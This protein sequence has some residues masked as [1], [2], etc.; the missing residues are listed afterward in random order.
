MGDEV[1]MGQLAQIV[2]KVVREEL[3][4]DNKRLMRELVEIIADGGKVKKGGNRSER[5]VLV[6]S[7]K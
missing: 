7:P 1:S 6:V 4:K 5:Q 3:E 2:R